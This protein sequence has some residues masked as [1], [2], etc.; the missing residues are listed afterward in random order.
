MVTVTPTPAT[1]A[2]TAPAAGQ[3]TV[4]AVYTGQAPVPLTVLLGPIMGQVSQV[5]IYNPQSGLRI[6]YVPGA[7][8][9]SPV[10]MPFSWLE[11]DV[12]QPVPLP[13]GLAPGQR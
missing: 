1:A 13:P 2:Q 4:T 10:V 8:A 7:S 12:T 3:G 6:V 11:I 9:F 5:R